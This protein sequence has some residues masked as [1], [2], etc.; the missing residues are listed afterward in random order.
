MWRPLAGVPLTSC[1]ALGPGPSYFVFLGSSLYIWTVDRCL[2]LLSTQGSAV[3]NRIVS[4]SHAQFL[5]VIVLQWLSWKIIFVMIFHQWNEKLFLSWFFI[6]GIV[7]WHIIILFNW[8]FLQ[9]F[10]TFIF[11]QLWAFCPVLNFLHFWTKRIYFTF[12]LLHLEIWTFRA[13]LNSSSCGMS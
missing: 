3:H 6:S 2:W 11:Q 4:T 5:K 7:W 10:K 1:T 9:S 12:F 8:Y 13:C